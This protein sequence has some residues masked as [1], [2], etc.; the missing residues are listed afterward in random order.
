MNTVN[1][2]SFLGP[3]WRIGVGPLPPPPWRLNHQQQIHFSLIDVFS[4]AL[5]SM[6]RAALVGVK[7]LWTRQHGGSCR[8]VSRVG[9][10]EAGSGAT[11]YSGRG[12]RVTVDI[13]VGLDRL[14]GGTEVVLGVLR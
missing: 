14:F 7:D 5:F 6:V 10:K 8:R 12:G 9:G 13:G 2:E 11:S 1:S 3:S 4:Y